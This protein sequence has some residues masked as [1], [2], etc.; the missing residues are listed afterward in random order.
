[1]H[2]FGC[3]KRTKDLFIPEVVGQLIRFHACRGQS[4]DVQDEYFQPFRFDRY[5]PSPDD[6]PGK[7]LNHGRF[8]GTGFSDRDRIV[9]RFPG[10]DLKHPS[11]CFITAGRRF[12]GGLLC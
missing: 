9:F 11:R 6:A 8:S 12:R 10:E 7:S 4:R 3:I 1:M 5:V 2:E